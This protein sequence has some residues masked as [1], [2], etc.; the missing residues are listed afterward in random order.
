MA[1]HVF[2]DAQNSF[3]S[4]SHLEVQEGDHFDVNYGEGQVNVTSTLATNIG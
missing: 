1:D 3:A 2:E 4:E